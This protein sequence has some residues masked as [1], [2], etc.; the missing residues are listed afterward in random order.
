MSCANKLQLSFLPITDYFYAAERKKLIDNRWIKEKVV[1]D[2]NAAK[3]KQH[4]AE[5]PE[6]IKKWIIAILVF[7]LIGDG[8]VEDLIEKKMAN[9]DATR[10]AYERQKIANEDIHNEVYSELFLLLSTPEELQRLAADYMSLPFVKRKVDFCR[11]MIELNVDFALMIMEG[12]FFSSSFCSIYFIKNMNKMPCL[13]EANEYIAR[14]EGTHTNVDIYGYNSYKNEY[15]N[16]IM[17]EWITENGMPK[18]IKPGRFGNS[19]AVK[20]MKEAVEIEQ[21]FIREFCP[22]LNGMN[23]ALLSEYVEY[24]ADGNMQK[25]DHPT[26]YGTTNPFPFMEL[27]GKMSST[28]FFDKKPTE[29]NIF[30]DTKFTNTTDNDIEIL[31]KLFEK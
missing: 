20:F 7:F 25:M 9:F 17:N 28:N 15:N 22:T 10:K 16:W 31:D 8:E 5:F 21:E 12:I 1:N 11:R 3:D 2:I 29:Y 14:D 26:I 30:E 4:F 24:I 19:D 6:E 27:F 18:L 23:P 13:S